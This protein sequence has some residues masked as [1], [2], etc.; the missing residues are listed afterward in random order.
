MITWVLNYCQPNITQPLLC[1]KAAG[2]LYRIMTLP[3]ILIQIQ[4][5]TP[6]SPSQVC[7]RSV[8]K[9]IVAFP[10]EKQTSGY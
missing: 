1:L 6:L 9:R 2:S 5:P 4:L 8:V 3:T 7:Y 10:W